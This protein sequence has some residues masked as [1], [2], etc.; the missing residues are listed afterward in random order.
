MDWSPVFHAP[1]KTVPVRASRAVSG[2][3]LIE[4]IGV[5]AIIAILAVVTAPKVFSTISNSRVTSA[6]SS[7]N[8]VG[9]ALSDFGGKY[10]NIPTTTANS[11]VD[12]LLMSAGYLDQRFAIKIGTPPSTPPIA[13]AAWAYANGAWTASGGSSQAT[14]SR[15]ICLRSNA[16][17]PSTAAGANYQLD[18]S[19]N[20][21]AGSLVISA[22]IP[23][24]TGQQAHELSV[25]VDGDSLSAADNVTADNA[26]KVVYA[27]PN[28]NG[29]TT[30]YVYIAQQ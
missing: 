1:M 3:S 24:L 2:F 26:G 10:G 23:N 19:T 28:G 7:I 9:S 8:A 27:A 16:N 15:I 30:A 11:R 13:G 21:P 5:L 14:Q 20:L 17:T 4:M 25:A 29:L 6:V 12:D 22:V 18:G